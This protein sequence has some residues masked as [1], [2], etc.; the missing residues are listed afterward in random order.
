MAT[1][2]IAVPSE[3]ML[4]ERA[5]D[6]FGRSG[7]E[8]TT[9]RDIAIAAG[10]PQLELYSAFPSKEALL[11]ELA[12]RAVDGILDGQAM[13]LSGPDD[14]VESLRKFVRFHAGWHAINGPL[15]RVV[16]HNMAS[17]TADHRREFFALRSIYERTFRRLL[18]TGSSGGFFDIP[19]VRVTTYAIL[20]M[21]IEISVWYR[22][23]GELTPDDLAS[24]HEELALRMVGYC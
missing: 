8:A 16:N 18:E 9:M 20:Q 22:P 3:S 6:L 4:L 12:Q 10:I 5:L 13:A 21:G 23:G 17:L 7:Y 24:L 2:V 1:D 15:A 11:W 14:V 19:N